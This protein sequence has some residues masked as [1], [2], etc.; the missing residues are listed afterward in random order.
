MMD[1]LYGLIAGITASLFSFAINS[2]ILKRIGD[3]AV[4]IYIPVIEE[5]SK[6]CFSL[7]IEGNIIFCHMIFGTVEALYDF[8]TTPEKYSL[9]A[10]VLSLLSHTIF[11]VITFYVIKLSG[12]SVIAVLVAVSIHSMWNRF[13]TG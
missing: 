10:S 9:T 6:T 4:N 5:F 11:G 12:F 2:Y 8:Y 3:T 13:I 1:M 7:I